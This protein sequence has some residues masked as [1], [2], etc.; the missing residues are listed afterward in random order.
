MVY[1]YLCD[2]LYI[3]L[4]FLFIYI[5]TCI[6][7]FHIILS[8]LWTLQSPRSCWILPLLIVSLIIWVPFSEINIWGVT[9]YLHF[10]CVLCLTIFAEFNTVLK[11]K[12]AS[13]YKWFCASLTGLSF[14]CCS[15]LFYRHVYTLL[16]AIF[17]K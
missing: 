3:F 17:Y 16:H 13:Y 15:D 9:C 11:M 1:I 10:H 12:I 7:R 4:L 6:D 14:S 2:N 5:Y 8:I